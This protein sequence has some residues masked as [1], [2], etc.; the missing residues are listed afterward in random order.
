MSFYLDTWSGTGGE[1]D[2]FR[3][4]LS[5]KFPGEPY[6][7]IDL[8]RDPTRAAGRCIVRCQKVPALQL[9]AG[10]LFLAD[11]A[12]DPVALATRTLIENRLGL[13]PGD[14]PD[15][16]LG[17]LTRR[18]LTDLAREDGSRW[19]SMRPMG[20]GPNAWEVHCGELVDAIPRFQGGATDH[21][22]RADA[23][24]ISPSAEG[25]GW[26]SGGPG[27]DNTLQVISNAGRFLRNGASNYVS[28]AR[29]E[30]VLPSDNMYAECMVET[31]TTS[32]S[33]AGPGV[34]VSKSNRSGY[35]FR[36]FHD[37][38]AA[39]ELVRYTNDLTLTILATGPT[40]TASDV[41]RVAVNGSAVSYYVNGA[42]I[43][44][45]TDTVIPTG[46]YPGVV[47]DP[48]NGNNRAGMENFDAQPL[49]AW[50]G[51]V[52]RPVADIS[53]SGW[54]T[55]PLWSTLDDNDDADY[56]ISGNGGSGSVY[57]FEVKLG[58]LSAPTSG[59]TPL[60]RV[61]AGDEGAETTNLGLMELYQG[62]TLIAS[63]SLTG[64]EISLA[65][66]TFDRYL[67]ASE[68]AAITDWS[69]LRVRWTT[70]RSSGLNRAG[71]VAWIE[72]DVPAS[73]GGGSGPTVKVWNGTTEVAATVTVWNGTA[74]VSAVT[75]EVTS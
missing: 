31:A 29:P 25:W 41:L 13:A 54:T 9:P 38:A 3:P 73:A 67:S 16:P 61:R 65:S 1:D 45:V 56:I 40:A 27:V 23:N 53:N 5:A 36:R 49:T 32:S 69:D 17:R 6:V 62:A 26:I 7:A 71:R 10:T 39:T 50:P 51:Q 46:N 20:V 74:E 4:S 15:L 43:G 19:R 48:R 58:A 47:G 63:R 18:I 68:M 11:T 44:T 42:L 72:L 8:R 12:G 28:I 57:T 34:R 60:F 70:T 21:F 64:T 22:N 59:A 55:A 37:N 14:L 66:K 24:P 2:P 52:S 30:V 33:F 75:I 35:F